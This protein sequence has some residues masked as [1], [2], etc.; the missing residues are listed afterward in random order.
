V[1]QWAA[2]SDADREGW[3]NGP[4]SADSWM[5]LTDGELAELSAE[6]T[7]LIIRW[8]DRPAPGDGSQRR[9]VFVFAR[10]VPGQP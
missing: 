6:L 8:A 10:G 2:A 1:R 7:A 4:F 3:T 9:P 5:R